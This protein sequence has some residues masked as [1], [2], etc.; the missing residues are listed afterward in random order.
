MYD[1]EKYFIFS[2]WFRRPESLMARCPL[3]IATANAQ[4]L[5]FFNTIPQGSTGILKGSPTLLIVVH[6]NRTC[7]REANLV[8]WGVSYVETM[9]VV[10]SHNMI[11]FLIE[12]V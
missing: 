6:T 10:F 1:F 12:V 2:S 9:K 5:R 4:R 3:Y 8:D 7:S 11:Y